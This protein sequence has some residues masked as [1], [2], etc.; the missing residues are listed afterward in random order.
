M[1][2]GVGHYEVESACVVVL[3][4]QKCL[5]TDSLSE[6]ILSMPFEGNMVFIKQAAAS[7]NETVLSTANRWRGM[8]PL[9][10]K[11]DATFDLYREEIMSHQDVIAPKKEKPNIA[12]DTSLPFLLG[13][14]P[15]SNAAEDDTRIP[16]DIY[17]RL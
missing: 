4:L 8:G 2:R 16:G 12:N 10:Q 7:L 17:D 3:F 14:P 1:S 6:K 5:V 9:L 11:I 15:S 13:L